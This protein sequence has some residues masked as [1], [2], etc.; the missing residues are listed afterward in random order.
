MLKFESEN[1]KVKNLPL[2]PR[3]FCLVMG[4]YS[5]DYSDL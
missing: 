1:L 2:E 5:V 4:S 3:L